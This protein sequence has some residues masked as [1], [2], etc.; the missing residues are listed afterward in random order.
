M[1]EGRYRLI[2]NTRTAAPRAGVSGEN[3][4]IAAG[5]DAVYLL[6]CGTADPNETSGS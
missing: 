3:A 4:S 6:G 1:G 2:G 5:D